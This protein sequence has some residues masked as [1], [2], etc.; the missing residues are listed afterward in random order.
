MEYHIN[1]IEEKINLEPLVE[2]YRLNNG[3]LKSNEKVILR[4]EVI[5]AVQD[6]KLY[7]YWLKNRHSKE[8]KTISFCKWINEMLKTK[9]DLEPFDFLAE[10]LIIRKI[11]G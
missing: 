10:D 1:T 11:L 7:R 5:E 6:Y 3:N 8:S 9:Y 2:R 4:K